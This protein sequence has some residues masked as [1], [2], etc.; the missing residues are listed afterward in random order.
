MLVEITKER[1]EEIVTT[2]NKIDNEELS[3]SKVT[4]TRQSFWRLLGYFDA[5]KEDIENHDRNYNY[6]TKLDQ[7]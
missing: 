5:I 2:L 4:K 3:D 6:T 7:E 1:C